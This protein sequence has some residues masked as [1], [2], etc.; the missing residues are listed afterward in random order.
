MVYKEG[1]KYEVQKPM[2][3][4]GKNDEKPRMYV[5]K[6]IFEGNPNDAEYPAALE[7]VKTK[8]PIEKKKT[9]RGEK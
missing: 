4:K 7:Q 2:M 5:F 8:K 9:K 3:A 6:E 1:N